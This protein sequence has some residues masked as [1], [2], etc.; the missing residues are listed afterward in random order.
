MLH[1][2]NDGLI[3]SPLK[4]RESNDEN[5]SQLPSLSTF[6]YNWILSGAFSDWIDRSA[7]RRRR[8]FTVEYPPNKPIR[9]V[10][11]ATPIYESVELSRLRPRDD[12]LALDT[13]NGR[14]R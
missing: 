12:D 9:W 1:G 13:L 11:S 6:P 5:N 14:R 3:Q 2:S 7:Q 8:F 4:I 10:E